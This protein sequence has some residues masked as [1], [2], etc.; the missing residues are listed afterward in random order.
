MIVKNRMKK[1]IILAGVASIL[2]GCQAGGQ[3]DNLFTKE[4]VGAVTGAAAGAW[5]GSNV[6]GGK[7]NIAAIAA[8]TLLGGY[9]GKTVGASL[10]KADMQYYNQTSQS[11]LENSRTGVT[12]A[13]NNPDTG[14]SG[15]IT[16]TRTYQN[17]T[18]GN[19]REYTQTINIGGQIERGYGTAC[20]DANGSWQITQ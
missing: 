4:N 20:R 1:F 7:G 6:G 8:G 2:A 5:I 12:S 11:A 3:N 9:L 16:P 17:P 15:T 18:G 14:N 10:D 13:W 19:C